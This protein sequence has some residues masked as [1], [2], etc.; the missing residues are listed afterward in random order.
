M[1]MEASIKNKMSIILAAAACW[2]LTICSHLTK[3][4]ELWLQV[5]ICFIIIYH[6]SNRKYTNTVASF[7][8]VCTHGLVSDWLSCQQQCSL[9]ATVILTGVAPLEANIHFDENCNCN[10]LTLIK[11][12]VTATYTIWEVVQKLTKMCWRYGISCHQPL[13]AN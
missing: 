5:I 9:K 8:Q 11:G 12:K 2:H 7:V 1:F 3:N 10:T 13:T 4:N 6:P